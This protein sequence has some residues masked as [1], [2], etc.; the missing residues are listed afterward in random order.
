MPLTMDK[1]KEKWELSKSVDV[2]PLPLPSLTDYPLESLLSKS[3]IEAADC[4]ENCPF[5]KHQIHFFP[6][7]LHSHQKLS[8]LKSGVST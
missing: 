1:S 2:A 4:L 8:C 5:Q 7:I 3:P 6:I